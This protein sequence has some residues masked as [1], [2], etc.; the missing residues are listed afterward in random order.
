MNIYQ[1]LGKLY[2]NTQA[3]FAQDSRNS[4]ATLTGIIT[5]GV[6]FI[7]VGSGLLSISITA[8]YLGKEQLGV[9]LL[10]S[11]LMNWVSLADFGLTNSLTNS[12]ATAL[13]RADRQT[14]QQSV[15]STF[16]PMFGLGIC[17][18]AIAIG[19]AFFT[20]WEQ[21]LHLNISPS[22]QQ[23]TRL[24]IAIL[25]C[26]FAIRIPLSIPRCIYNAYQ[27]GYTYQL[28][29]GVANILALTSLF[30]AQYYQANLPWLIAS[31]YGMVV[32]GDMLAGIHLLYFRQ[33]WL[34]PKLANCNL[35]LFK[36][37]IKVGF[38]FWIAQVCSICIFQ[39]DL[40]IISQLF[41][42]IEVGTYGIFLK[43]FSTIEVVSSSFMLPL[44]PAYNDAKARGDYQWINKTFRLSLI[45]ASIWAISAGSLLV[46]IS[47]ILIYHLLGKDTF[48]APELP[49][50]MLLTYILLPI[51]N[52]IS[53]LINGLG[54]MKLTS[55]VAPIAAVTN[56]CLSI[57]LGGI[58]GVQGVTLATAICV[59]IFSISIVGINILPK[60]KPTN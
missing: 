24:A 10:L 13:A 53:M 41:G 30:V 21:I 33:Q 17:L 18:L 22:L 38:Q 4:Q 40:I 20:P 55:I 25:L 8:G 51:S 6:R 1:K 9:W 32:L 3:K 48:F 29:V 57:I 28:W 43:I 35:R 12:L 59:L 31:F 14:A 54:E 34:Q 15:A 49:F 46:F 11:T 5:L 60:L 44:W 45:G 42:A 37:L 27:Q 50:Y 56:L 2:R 16:F 52:C 7:S 19:S 36:E 39:T 26:L 47:P 58:M 23:D